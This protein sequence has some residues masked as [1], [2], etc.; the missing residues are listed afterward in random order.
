MFPF[1]NIR[2]YFS[3]E[4]RMDRAIK[5]V[6]SKLAKMVMD[7]GDDSLLEDLKESVMG[8]ALKYG[9]HAS[10]KALLLDAL[11]ALPDMGAITELQASEL[12]A[13]VAEGA[14]RG[15]RRAANAVPPEPVSEIRAQLE[16]EAANMWLGNF[17]NN[18]LDDITDADIL[19]EN[20]K[21]ITAMYDAR[22]THIIYYHPSK[23][24]RDY[25]QDF[26]KKKNAEPSLALLA[27]AKDKPQ[28]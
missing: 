13:A 25:A 8:L 20:P 4:A 12:A 19:E 5:G 10:V 26:L 3:D 6:E 17:S 28:P 15:G 23:T 18:Y 24:M 14:A 11:E 27:G 21:T 7:E 9:H 22:A 1:T 2:Q 16:E